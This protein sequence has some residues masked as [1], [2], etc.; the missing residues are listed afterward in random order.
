MTLAASLPSYQAE[1]G[2]TLARLVKCVRHSTLAVS[3]ISK[4]SVA[5]P[6]TVSVMPC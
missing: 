2:M 4:A 1:A 6:Q 5:T 3:A